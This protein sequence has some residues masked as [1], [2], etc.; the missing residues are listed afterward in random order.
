MMLGEL[1]TAR[2]IGVDIALIVVNNA[3]SGY[4]KALQHLMYGAGAY[5]ASDLAETNYAEVANA[6]GCTGIRVEN[7]EQMGP[8]IER[9][10][11]TQGP[12]VLDVVV[13][14]DPPK[15]LPAVD[16]RTVQVKKGDRVA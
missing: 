16:N 11:R 15:M 8:A 3:A 9:A 5:H 2:R 13:T 1:E 10:F 14:R 12:V 4:V 7:P 6:L